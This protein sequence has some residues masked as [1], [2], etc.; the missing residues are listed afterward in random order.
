MVFLGV[1]LMQF[2]LGLFGTPESITSWFP[3]FPF[4]V[5]FYAIALIGSTV[6]HTP[7]REA[8]SAI[9]AR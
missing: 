3:G 6:L 4:H 1:S 8:S 7:S 2:L 5:P 9:T